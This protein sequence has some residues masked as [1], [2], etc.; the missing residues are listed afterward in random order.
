MSRKDRLCH[1]CCSNELGDEYHYIMSCSALERERKKLLPI[2]CNSNPNIYK[3]QQLFN[4]S[5]V[6]ISEKL[7][8]F[9]RFINVKVAPP[10]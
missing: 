7:C 6:I 2:Y 1:L 5:N 8:R 9:I 4:S 3:F 10:G